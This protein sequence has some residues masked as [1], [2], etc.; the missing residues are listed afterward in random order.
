VREGFTQEFFIEG[1]RSR[2]GK[3]LAPRMGMLAWSVEA[4]LGSPQRDLFFVPTAITYERLVEEGAM[5]GELEGE[6]KREE[7]MLGLMRARR[8]LGRRFGSVYVNFGEPISLAAALGPN[9]RRLAGDEDEAVA[10]EK[11]VLVEQIAHRIVERINW[12]AVANATAVASAVLLGSGHRGMLRAQVTQRMRELVELLRL[13][14]VRITP[15]LLRD[16]PDYDESISFLL[17]SDLLERAEDPRGEVLFFQESRRRALDL[18][19]NAILHFLAAPSFLARRLLR[20]ASVEELRED[21]AAWQE[22]LYQ[23]FYSPRG[24]ILAA[25]FEAFLDHF[26]GA[27]WVERHGERVVATEAGRAFFLCLAEQTRAIIEAYY[28]AV[29]TAERAAGELTLKE[30]R[31]QANEQFERLRLLGEVERIE[32]A[33]DITFGNAL[34]LLVRRG[35]LERR[36]PRGKKEEGRDPVYARGERFD[37]LAALR[38]WL[39]S[40]LS[41]R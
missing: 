22:L 8:V 16:A 3:T 19:R 11:R 24:E 5:V 32:G 12:A 39:A 2:T 37:E 4:F 33:N 26:A 9:R 30:F 27:G 10:A 41:A 14:D 40:P 18:Y 20:G 35:M 38:S 7:S 1:G 15:A 28:V 13:Q 25:H 17:R 34:D 36:E 6:R 23:E 21:L 31:K 29:A